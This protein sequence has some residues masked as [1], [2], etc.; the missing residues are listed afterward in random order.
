MR[1]TWPLMKNTACPK[2]GAIER[3]RGEIF[4]RGVPWDVR[5]KPDVASGESLKEQVV[6]LAAGVGRK[7]VV[8]LAC[9]SCGYIELF[10]ADHE[11]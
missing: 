5:F 2:C 10:L 7:R 8:A 3:E 6:A 9:P 11:T 4:P 1:R